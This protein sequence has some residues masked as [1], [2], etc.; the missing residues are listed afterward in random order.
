MEIYT[1]GDSHAYNG[2]E[3]IDT[4][5]LKINMHNIGAKLCYSF[6]RDKL[7]CLNIKD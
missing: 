4:Y 3:V 5:K 7:N 1:F 6:G 2:W